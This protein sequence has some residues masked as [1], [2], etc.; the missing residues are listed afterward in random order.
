MKRLFSTP[1]LSAA[2]AALWLLLNWP[3]PGHLLIAIV[4]ALALPIMS[5]PL[6]PQRGA[7]RRPWVLVR[8]IM[9]VGRD[10]VGSALQVA[11]GVLAGRRRPPDSRFVRVPLDLR[12]G[13]GLA[14]LAVITTAVPGTVWSEL[15]ADRSS[16]LLHVFDLENGD[17][18]G[19]IA[20]YKQRYERPLMEI[21]E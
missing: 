19:F 17:A 9:A 2:L 8:L 21:F 14:A 3:T 6:R 12:D 11:R 18:A 20:Q 16:L 13:H 5:A 10:V 4:L 7:V 15:A 1:L